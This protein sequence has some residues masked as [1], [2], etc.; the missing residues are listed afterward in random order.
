MKPKFRELDFVTFYQFGNLVS[1]R[2]K[3]AIEEAELTGV[4]FYELQIPIEFSDE[5]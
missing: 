3:N 1:E 5:I 4:E 2:L